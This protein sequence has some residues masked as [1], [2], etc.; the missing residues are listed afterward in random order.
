MSDE[1]VSEVENTENIQNNDQES[2]VSSDKGN[3]KDDRIAKQSQELTYLTS[4]VIPNL[5]NEIK[6]LKSFKSELTDALE[7]STKKYYEQL[8][9]NALLSD[10]L[11]K[12]S[13][14][15]AVNK[16]RLEKLDSTI[17]DVKKDAKDKVDSYKAKL[18]QFDTNKIKI[19]KDSNEKMID[20]LK[21]K[22]AKIEEL[23]SKVPALQNEVMD[24]RNKLIEL[25]NYKEEVDAKTTRT[26]NQYKDTINDL[27]RDLNSKQSNYDRLYNDSQKSINDLKSQVNKY[28][29]ALNEQSN[30]GFFDRL[31]NKQVKLDDD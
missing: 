25:G 5:K 29:K 27:N 2:N 23:E 13:A 10:K 1:N 31:S 4:N 30:R 24:L 19:L 16:V 11:T 7:A 9:I 22:D 12:I 8:D 6:E 28:K 20:E 14:E 26:I 3:T 17:D 18:A 15:S 21:E